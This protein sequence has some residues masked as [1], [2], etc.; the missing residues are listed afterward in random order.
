MREIVLAAA[1]ASALVLPGDAAP[2]TR[3]AHAACKYTAQAVCCPARQGSASGRRPAL[4]RTRAGQNAAARAAAAQTQPRSHPQLAAV[5]PVRRRR[6]PARCA[7]P[8]RCPPRPGPALSPLG[9]APR[10]PWPRAQRRHRPAPRRKWAL[11]RERGGACV[12]TPPGR[13][14][15]SHAH[16]PAS[17]AP[18][19]PPADVNPQASMRPTFRGRPSPPPPAAAPSAWSR[20]YGRPSSSSSATVCSAQAD[21]PSAPTAGRRPGA[22]AAAAVAGWVAEAG[23]H[24]GRAGRGALR[25]CGLRTWRVGMRPLRWAEAGSYGSAVRT[26][27]S[28]IC[29]GPVAAPRLAGHHMPAQ[30]LRLCRA[31][32]HAS[33]LVGRQPAAQGH[34][35][36]RRPAPRAPGARTPR[37]RAWAPCAAGPCLQ[38]A[39]A[40]VRQSSSPPGLKTTSSRKGRGP[41]RAA[42]RSEAA[43]GALRVAARAQHPPG[44]GACW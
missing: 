32:A 28:G 2:T 14:Q 42:A 3:S 8:R 22:A 26:K 18:F 9:W 24:V 34:A 20:L 39:R 7:R 5:T 6:L 19:P 33:L 17:L 36:A 21:Q 10:G 31:C 35:P 12:L 29:G 1:K 38:A 13:A 37:P 41:Q 40:H 4:Q 44:S 27:L 30:Q 23:R 11:R 16:P 25:T 43:R 15:R